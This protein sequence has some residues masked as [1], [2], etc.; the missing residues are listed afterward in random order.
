MG[1]DIT[2]NWDENSGD[3]FCDILQERPFHAVDVVWLPGKKIL[4]FEVSLSSENTEHP[5][6]PPDLRLRNIRLGTHEKGDRVAMKLSQDL[7]G[8]PYFKMRGM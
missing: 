8:R 5:Q 6:N 4:L 7:H 3:L 1:G 2:L